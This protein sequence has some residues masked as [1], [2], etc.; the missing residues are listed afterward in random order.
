MKTTLVLLL[1]ISS[2]AGLAAQGSPGP[3]PAT[4]QA[5]EKAVGFLP[6]RG[7]ESG[8]E[9]LFLKIAP[10]P[11]CAVIARPKVVEIFW[12]PNFAN[13][14][15]PDYA[16]AQAQ[17]A[18]RNQLGTSHVWGVLLQYG[19][20]SVNLG[21]GTPDW[22]DTTTPPTNVTDAKVQT[23]V[24]TYLATHAFDASTIYEVFIPST[25]YSSSGGST[26]CG[27]PSLAYCSYDS[28]YA[29]GGSTVRYTIQPYPSCSGCQVSGWTAAQN[30][31]HQVEHSTVD[32]VTFG[33][34]DRTGNN[35]AD[36]CAWSPAPFLL[37]GFGYQYLWS[38]SA[39]ACAR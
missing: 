34:V 10:P 2:A 36:K 28:S 13:P 1:L 17:I 26:S 29:H 27:G 6:P 12:G 30:Q 14:A 22:F 33:C 35:L 16:Y 21:A 5:G 19:V 38:A 8:L 39:G 20:Q 3:K 4:S 18:Y 24:S 37:N 15:L 31:E 32:A 7:Q 25:S 9:A 11:T 23:E